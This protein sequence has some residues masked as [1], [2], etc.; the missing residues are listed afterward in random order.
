MTDAVNLGAHLRWLRV[1]GPNG[2]LKLRDVARRINVSPA[3]WSH[4]ENN[5]ERPDRD[6]LASR[7]CP[8]LGGGLGELL[9]L[10][11]TW[12]EAPPPDLT[13]SICVGRPAHSDGS[14]R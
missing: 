1:N 12:A 8:M 14:V 4:W 13:H 9:R 2:Y 11:E 6:L 10:W 5:R 7:I 3:Q